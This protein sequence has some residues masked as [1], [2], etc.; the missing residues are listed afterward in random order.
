[1]LRIALPM[2]C[3]LAGLA[4]LPS[5]SA[6]P[7]TTRSATTKPATTRAA[8]TQPAT[9]AELMTAMIDFSRDV[10]AVLKTATDEQ[11]ANAALP[12]LEAARQRV[13]H[14]RDATE[15]IGPM[16]DLTRQELMNRHGADFQSATAAVTAEVERIKKD[17]AL[18]AILGQPI[19]SLSVFRAKAERSE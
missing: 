10:A 4:S 16:N 6:A 3:L 19:E 11:T 9:H 18:S 7:A 15:A 13:L 5:S 2:A 12:K 1:M 8:A 14:L 17:P